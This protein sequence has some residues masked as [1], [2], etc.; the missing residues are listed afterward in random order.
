[1]NLGRTIV[2]FVFTLVFVGCRKEKPA[3]N[4]NQSVNSNPVIPVVSNHISVKHDG[5]SMM[6][7]RTD[8]SLVISP[9][10]NGR[11]LTIYGE[12]GAAAEYIG[13]WLELPD[14]GTVIKTGQYFLG[15]NEIFHYGRSGTGGGLWSLQRDSATL[16]ITNWEKE[17]LKVSGTFSGKL[18]RYGAPGFDSVTISDGTFTNLSYVISR[19]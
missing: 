18:H 7:T 6:A 2:L 10:P 9:P 12:S 3:A 1:M 17:K 11:M 13:I 15:P 5:Q 14:T 16:T 4:S 8:A 19:L